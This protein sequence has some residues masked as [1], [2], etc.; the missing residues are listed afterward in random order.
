MLTYLRPAIVMIVLFTVLTGIVYPLAVTGI[1]QLIVPSIANGSL[2]VRNGNVVGS[3]LI[4]QTFTGD[5]YFHG[6]P[7][8]AGQN[9]YDA[10]ASSGSNLGPISKKLMDRVTE[11]A[12]GL[13]EQGATLVP[14]DAVTASASGLDPD[15]SPAYAEWQIDR[16]ARA[17]GWPTDRVR[18]LVEAATDAPLFGLVGERKVNV[19]KLNLALDAEPQARSG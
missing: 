1:A 4:G 9:G 7:S 15:I 18:A 8:A 10:A 16:I 6:R 11:A 19:L 2:V 5:G 13:R 3:K 14:A 17:R 12:K